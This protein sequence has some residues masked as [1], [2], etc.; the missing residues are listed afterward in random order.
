M[1]FQIGT[2]PSKKGNFEI[3]DRLINEV[4]VVFSNNFKFEHDEQHQLF[5]NIDLQVDLWKS[6]S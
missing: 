3:K 5:K 6:Y 2:H 4:G 1:L